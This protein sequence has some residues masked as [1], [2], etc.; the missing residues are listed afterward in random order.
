GIGRRPGFV[1]GVPGL[2]WTINGHLF[3]DVPM[4]VVHDGD[5]VQM[6]ISNT[7]GEVHP[8]HLHGHH[9]VVL[10]RNGTAASGSPWWVDSLNVNDG[11]AYDI[12]FRAANPGCGWTT[13]T[14]CSMPR[15]ASSHT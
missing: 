7:S 6:H 3:P 14:T 11:E 4:F 1:D 8:M 12:A 5:I 9:A 10:R 13:A 15:T 2:W